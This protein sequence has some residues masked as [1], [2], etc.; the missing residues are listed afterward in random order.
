LHLADEAAAAASADASSSETKSTAAEG[1]AA[2]AAAAVAAA[3]E[4][5][6]QPAAELDDGASD[7]GDRKDDEHDR[8]MQLFR[9]HQLLLPTHT[10][11]IGSEWLGQ[12][13]LSP[14][15]EGKQAGYTFFPFDSVISK[16]SGDAMPMDF[17]SK[18]RRVIAT[19]HGNS[20]VRGFIASVGYKSMRL[21]SF[22]QRALIVLCVVLPSLRQGSLQEAAIRVGLRGQH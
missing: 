21:F 10:V 13:A 3:G 15:F 8:T 4:E 20:T 2:S 1:S 16:F 6:K 12:K 22:G 14:W 18:K 19:S 17:H 5:S 11:A 7:S 9:A